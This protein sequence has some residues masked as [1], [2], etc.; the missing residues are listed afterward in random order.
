[1]SDHERIVREHADRIELE[2]ALHNHFGRMICAQPNA[3]VS[4]VVR[5][6]EWAR[7]ACGVQ[8][9]VEDGPPGPMKRVSELWRPLDLPPDDWKP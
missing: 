6:M 2:R 9:V 3:M 5:L 4:E 1:M 7:R 8:M